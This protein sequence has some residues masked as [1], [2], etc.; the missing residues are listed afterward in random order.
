MKP[1][2]AW[3]AQA[4]LLK[5]ESVRTPE[6]PQGAKVRRSNRE[7]ATLLGKSLSAVYIALNKKSRDR[8]NRRMRESGYSKE[9]WYRR[10]L[11]DTSTESI[12]YARLPPEERARRNA[13]RGKRSG[14][15]QP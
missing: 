10:K 14:A 12:S 6:R 5:Y 1:E 4:R 13:H 8:K 2:P 9:Y 3:W 7:I 11:A 15:P